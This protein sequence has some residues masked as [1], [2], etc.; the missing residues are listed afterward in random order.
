MLFERGGRKEGERGVRTGLARMGS[1]LGIR[2]VL[3]KDRGKFGGGRDGPKPS[4][5]CRV[6][7]F[8]WEGA[9]HWR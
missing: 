2:A 8:E 6:S 3:L 7:V 9:L 1:R 4:E 5:T